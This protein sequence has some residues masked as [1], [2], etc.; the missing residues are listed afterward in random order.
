MTDKQKQQIIALRRNGAGYGTIA[1]QLGVSINTVKSFCR[2][3]SLVAKTAGAVCEQCGKPITQNPG[4]K[5]RGG[6]GNAFVPMHAGTSG[7]TATLTW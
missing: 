2:R 3:H 6:S 7:V 5:I 1:S 4:R